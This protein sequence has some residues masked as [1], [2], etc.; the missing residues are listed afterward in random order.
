MMPFTSLPCY[1]LPSNVLRIISEYSKPVTRPD[2]RT[3]GLIRKTEYPIDLYL[4]GDRI[5][6]YKKDL[7]L[8]NPQLF[9]LFLIIFTN[10]DE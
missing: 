8:Y 6:K 4:Y 2:W 7:V 3:C 9:K 1:S 5:Y 10:M